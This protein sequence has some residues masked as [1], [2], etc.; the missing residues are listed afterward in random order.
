M[1]GTFPCPDTCGFAK[2]AALEIE[3]QIRNNAKENSELTKGKENEYK[4][5]QEQYRQFNTN[6]NNKEDGKN[7]FEINFT[8]YNTN[9]IKLRSIVRKW[10]FRKSNEK[11]QYLDTFSLKQWK[12]L[13]EERKS[14]HRL[15]NC[16]GCA[17]RYAAVQAFFP[18]KSQ[19]LKGRIKSS[20]VLRAH[21]EAA[22]LK[23]PSV[24]PKRSDVKKSAKAIYEAISP[25][26]KNT[27]GTSFAEALA[28]VPES[29]LQTKKIP[30][31]DNQEKHKV[32]REQY[33]KAKENIEEQMKDTAFLR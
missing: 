17:V 3:E 29:Q 28:S 1:Y 7:N 30:N 5:K 33:R 16:R 24:K 2:V 31:K 6:F 9:L 20:P 27:F 25:T 12:K 26:F 14:E 23:S 4:L 18:V 22:K 10:N 8:K 32:R 19:F 13:S 11:R 21:N 15:A